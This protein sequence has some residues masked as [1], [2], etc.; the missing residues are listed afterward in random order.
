MTTPRDQYMRKIDSLTASEM[1]R[2]LGML[3]DDIKTGEPN[4]VTPASLPTIPVL[5]WVSNSLGDTCR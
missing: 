4:R 3:M 5:A 1:A 2:S